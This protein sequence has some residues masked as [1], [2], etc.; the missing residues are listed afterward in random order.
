MGRGVDPEE[1]TCYNNVLRVYP[2]SQQEHDLPVR[3]RLTD[4]HTATPSTSHTI[5]APPHMLQHPTRRI[6]TADVHL[7]FLIIWVDS[8]QT[9][10]IVSVTRIS[11][12]CKTH[13]SFRSLD[14]FCRKSIATDAL[15]LALGR[16]S[17]FQWTGSSPRA[18]H[19]IVLPGVFLCLLEYYP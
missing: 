13:L 9:P 15:M 3:L 11:V 19:A 8:E 4:E 2:T 1:R 12:T 5:R 17:C 14:S 7:G 10:T 18:P 6:I 16:R